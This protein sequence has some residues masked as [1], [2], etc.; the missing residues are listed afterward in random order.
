MART[1]SSPQLLP[2]EM[3]TVNLERLLSRLDKKLPPVASMEYAR[4]A[5]AGGKPQVEKGEI[6]GVV[7]RRKIAAVC[8]IEVFRGRRKRL[9][10]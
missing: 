10:G 2:A 8:S 6:P 9:M 5:G 7:E 3:V 1:I 4:G